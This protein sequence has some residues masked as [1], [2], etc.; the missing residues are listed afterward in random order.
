MVFDRREQ[1][2]IGRSGAAVVKKEEPLA[3]TPEWSGTKLIRACGTLSDII[4]QSR[5]HVVNQQV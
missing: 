1:A 2:T 5:S 3:K 4:R